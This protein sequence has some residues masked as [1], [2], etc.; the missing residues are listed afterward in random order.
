M[1]DHLISGETSASMWLFSIFSF[2]NAA[3]K[4]TKIKAKINLPFTA[5]L[6][7]F[8]FAMQMLNF[9]IPGTGSS[10]HFCGGM[11]LAILL[12]THVSFI[13]MSLI[14]AIQCFLFSDGGIMALGCNVFNL[15]FIPSFIVYPFFSS[16]IN[17][18]TNEV[19]KF[20]LTLIS[21]IIAIQLGAFSVV[22][23]TFFSFI[24]PLSFSKFL[25]LMLPIHFAIGIAE[26]FITAILIYIL[27]PAE[28]LTLQ[29]SNPI[30]GRKKYI[31]LILFL[32][33]AGILSAGILSSFSSENPDGL[34]WALAKTSFKESP[35]YT[36][37]I[38]TFFSEIQQYTSLFP[39]YQLESMGFSMLI[40]GIM[41]YFAIFATTI[42]F[43]TILKKSELK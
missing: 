41:G 27:L 24:T 39:D 30:K 38:K 33:I 1:S 14:L 40:P 4:I 21:S 29:T 23:E 6:A 36:S 10:G 8:V 16:I 42:I 3:T 26:G 15:A 2:S 43:L 11:L 22:L 12:G 25:S 20:F 13:V 35:L 17:S 5:A 34:E 18:D 7:G 31:N 9:T 32:I 37:D 19:K 28:N